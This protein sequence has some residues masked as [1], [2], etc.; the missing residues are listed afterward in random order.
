M[1]WAYPKEKIS[2]SYVLDCDDFNAN[3]AA[4]AAELD[5]NL[6]E[7]NWYASALHNAMVTL[8]QCADDIAI[9]VYH[10][11]RTADPTA[12]ATAT[13]FEIP[14]GTQWSAIELDNDG[15]DD[16]T[17]TSRGGKM[18]AFFQFNLHCDNPGTKQSGV[19]FCVELDGAPLMNALIGTGDDSNDFVP[20]DG[21]TPTTDWDTSASFRADAFPMRVKV[22]A[23]LQ[24]GQHVVRLLAR[25]LYQRDV[26]P[27]Q[28]ISQV[29]SIILDLW[30]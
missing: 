21:V 19:I 12:A 5:G 4:W 8:E 27:S 29:N 6:N 23:N 13:W 15:S 30:A 22:S 17:F 2:A 9:R 24:P 11:I 20:V 28:Y 14:H 1:S 26:V 18:E 25:N 7:H 3:I 16:I 10:R